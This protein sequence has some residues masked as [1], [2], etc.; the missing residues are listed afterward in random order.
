MNFDNWQ[1]RIETIKNN[2][3]RMNCTF[4]DEDDREGYYYEVK[5][6]DYEWLFSLIEAQRKLIESY[7]RVTEG[8]VEDYSNL[9]TKETTAL[10][11]KVSVTDTELF[12]EFFSLSLWMFRR[13]PKAHQEFAYKEI[14]KLLGGQFDLREFD[15]L[16]RG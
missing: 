16:K 6:T 2:V 1:E 14:V 9:K 13:L 10:T 5:D 15:E 7:G 4:G 8:M 12:K 11:V 3:H